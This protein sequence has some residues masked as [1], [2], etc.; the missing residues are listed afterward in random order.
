MVVP[1]AIHDPRLLA[2]RGGQPASTD[3]HD[4]T[5]TPRTKSRKRQN[6]ARKRPSSGYVTPPT[7]RAVG[8]RVSDRCA[9]PRSSRRNSPSSKMRSRPMPSRQPRSV[10]PVT[11]PLVTPTQRSGSASL[12]PPRPAAPRA[13]TRWLVPPHRPR[14]TRP[15]VRRAPATL[16][17]VRTAPIPRPDCSHTRSLSASFAQAEVSRT[18]SVFAPVAPN[19]ELQSLSQAIDRRLLQLPPTECAPRSG[20]RS[21]R[22]LAGH[23]PLRGRAP[24]CARAWASS[25]PR[26]LWGLGCALDSSARSTRR[27]KPPGTAL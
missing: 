12:A 11:R 26:L 15:S 24:R 8:I 27:R 1:T 13:S 16:A 18:R 22:R 5:H 21:I 10:H 25:T 17:L 7:E 3:N 23:R 6:L 9:I 4:H 19:S 20:A 14:T 2:Q